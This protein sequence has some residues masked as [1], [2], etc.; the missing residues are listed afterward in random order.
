MPDPIIEIPTEKT[1]SSPITV[2]VPNTW[3]IPLTFKNPQLSEARKYLEQ[4]LVEKPK[5]IGKN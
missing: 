5:F 4:W 3:T 1:I 2:E